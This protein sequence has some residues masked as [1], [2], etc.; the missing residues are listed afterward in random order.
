MNKNK[1]KGLKSE[2]LGTKVYTGAELR[3][4]SGALWFQKGDFILRKKIKDYEGLLFENKCTDKKSYSIKVTEMK[5]LIDEALIDD[6]IPV[7]RTE[8]QGE[9][10]ITIPEWVFK[11]FILEESDE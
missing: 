5:K 4:N 2:K 6:Y 1:K 8:I 11:Q 7:F 10:Y 3:K 9:V